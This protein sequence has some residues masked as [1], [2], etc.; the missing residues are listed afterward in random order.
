MSE[1]TF[2]LGTLNRLCQ[3][4]FQQTNVFII[5]ESLDGEWPYELQWISESFQTVV[6]PFTVEN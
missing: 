1:Y 2:K 3:G 5:L 6:K 4:S